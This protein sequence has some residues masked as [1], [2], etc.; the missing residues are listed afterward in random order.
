VRNALDKH[1]GE[2]VEIKVGK[3]NK[4]NLS[5]VTDTLILSKCKEIY[6]DGLTIYKCLI[7]AGVHK[8][9]RYGTNRIERKN[10]NLRTHL[11]R[12]S[13]KTI[14]YSKSLHMQEAC[15]KIYFWFFTNLYYNE[16]IRQIFFE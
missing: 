13:R 8:V 12:L 9:K 15:I 3:R 6:T 2:I 7:P 1:T 14:C 16:L 11:K 10:L 4:A 5:N